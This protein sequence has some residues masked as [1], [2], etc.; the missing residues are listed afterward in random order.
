M[1]VSFVKWDNTLQLAL[2]MT[3]NTGGEFKLHV[4]GAVGVTG[5]KVK[6]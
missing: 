4:T 2:H 6:K 1:R 3:T 5:N